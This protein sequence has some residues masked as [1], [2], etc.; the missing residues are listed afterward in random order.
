MDKKDE[1][2]EWKEK[3]VEKSTAGE[4]QDVPKKVKHIFLHLNF[5]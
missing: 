2:E 3:E 1:K 5:Y 4:E